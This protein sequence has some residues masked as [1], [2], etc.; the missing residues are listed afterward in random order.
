MSSADERCCIDCG[1]PG[2]IEYPNFN[3][4]GSRYKHPSL[5]AC[6]TILRTQINDLSESEDTLQTALEESYVRIAALNEKLAKR[7]TTLRFIRDYKL[8]GDGDEAAYLQDIARREL[9]P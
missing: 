6:I 3:N 4:M 1:E 5:F 7:E 8:T 2:A 9:K